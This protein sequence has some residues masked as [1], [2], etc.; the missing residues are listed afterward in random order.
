MLTEKPVEYYNAE[1][2]LERLNAL[3]EAG[4]SVKIDDVYEE[5]SIFDWW[6]EMLTINHMKA[7]RGF[8]KLAIEL[9]YK[10][11]VC[12]KVGAHCCANGMWACKAEGREVIETNNRRYIYSPDDNTGIY[13]SFTP[14]Y[15]YYAV[16]KDNKWYPGKETD[17]DPYD[18]VR[19]QLGLKRLHHFLYTGETELPN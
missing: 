8:L 12:F 3:I 18:S 10:G 4:K 5:L 7:M 1:N 16:N 15:L 17:G 6:P 9:G 2:V 11:Y 13:R 19:T 14:D